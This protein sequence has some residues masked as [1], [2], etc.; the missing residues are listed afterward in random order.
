MAPRQEWASWCREQS[1]APQGAEAPGSPCLPAAPAPQP[2]STWLHIPSASCCLP[3]AR[4]PVRHP[5]QAQPSPVPATARRIV[6][7]DTESLS[8]WDT[9]PLPSEPQ[10]G[11]LWPCSHCFSPQL[12]APSHSEQEATG[13][14][15][16]QRLQ[17]CWAGQ[18]DPPSRILELPTRSQKPW[19][20]ASC[21]LP[22]QECVL[23]EVAGGG[24]NGEDP[25][26]KPA[27][28][29]F[30][31]Q[32]CLLGPSVVNN[33]NSSWHFCRAYHV[34]GT[35]LHALCC[36]NPVQWCYVYLHFTHRE[37][38]GR[39]VKPLA[40]HDTAGKRPLSM[41]WTAVRKDHPLALL[42][43]LAEGQGSSTLAKP[44]KHLG[45][46]V[47]FLFLGHSSHL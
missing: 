8:A 26:P 1:Q 15:G 45:N 46:F 23:G 38:E 47:D 31:A 6:Q 16:H 42:W 22:S 44:G 33:N 9:T 27:G 32:L 5:P 41:T 14:P 10:Q 21:R 39:A 12:L 11:C 29:V 17:E 25:G 30:E 7:R 18:A 40:P 35:V 13:L 36:S 24:Q 37:T 34:P 28:L 19:A 4:R 3:Q 20:S 43:I 2:K